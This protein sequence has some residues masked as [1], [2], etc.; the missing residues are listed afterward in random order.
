MVWGRSKEGPP[1]EEEG[2][3]PEKEES[4]SLFVVE[5]VRSRLGEEG[6]PPVEVEWAGSLGDSPA[7]AGR[8]ESGMRVNNGA[9]SVN[10]WLT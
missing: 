6:V 2:F 5:S 9:T 3:P 4:F 1:P 8:A 10:T 7:G